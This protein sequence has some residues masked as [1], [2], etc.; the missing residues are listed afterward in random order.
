MAG[1]PPP[2]VGWHPVAWL[3]IQGASL[4]S[5]ESKNLYA[6]ERTF[7]HWVHMSVV[8]GSIATGLLAFAKRQKGR[9]EMFAIQV[10]AALLIVT[11]ISFIVYALCMFLWRRKVIAL[12]LGNGEAPLG[13]LVLAS[14]FSVCLVSIFFFGVVQPKV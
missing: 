13:P 11:A 5:N 6:N 7:I 9:D 3:S 1:H 12:K 2:V 10:M 4:A 8:M 14:V